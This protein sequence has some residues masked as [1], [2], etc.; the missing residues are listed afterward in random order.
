MI[1]RVK[2]TFNTTKAREFYRKLTDGT[3]AQQRPDGPEIVRSMQRAT[4]DEQGNVHWTERCFCP[5]PLQHE[6]ATV[7]DDYFTDLAV[8]PVDKTIALEGAS[9]MEKLAQM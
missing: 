6:R 3:I 2:A 7:Y 1:Y 4:V 9:F 5:T 8:E